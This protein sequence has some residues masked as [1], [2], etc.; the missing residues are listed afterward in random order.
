MELT[1][2]AIEGGKWEY[3]LIKQLNGVCRI[4]LFRDYMGITTDFVK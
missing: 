3:T 2:A 1:S 4:W